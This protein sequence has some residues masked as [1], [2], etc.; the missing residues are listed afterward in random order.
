MPKI[1]L[2]RGAASCLLVLLFLFPNKTFA[3]RT[4][5][6]SYPIPPTN[7]AV[8][9][10]MK[11]AL[12][13]LLKEGRDFR[14]DEAAVEQDGGGFSVRAKATFFDVSSLELRASFSGPAAISQLEVA[15]P[16]S[17]PERSALRRLSGQ[18]LLDWVPEGLRNSVRLTRLRMGFENNAVSLVGIDLSSAPLKLFDQGALQVEALV[19]SFEV[20][21]PRAPAPVVRA[22]ISGQANAGFPI[23]VSATVANQ[24]DQWVLR[25]ETG[26]L[27]LGKVLGLTGVQRPAEWPDVL[28][29][30]G[31]ASG[32]IE[33]E[34]F[35]RRLSLRAESDFGQTEFA[36][37]ARPGAEPQ[38]LAGIALPAN[39]RFASIEPSLVVLDQ[40]GLSN[41]ALAL[42]SD[43]QT[44]S[45]KLFERLG[46]SPR[47]DRG[48][49][50]LAAYQISALS[51]DLESFMGQSNVLLRATIS[52]RPADLK[53]EAGL[54]TNIPFDD[55]GN[56]VLRGV[57]LT[58]APT[59]ASFT[60]SLG[61]A[62]DVRMEKD[63]LTFKSKI[64]VDLTNVELQVEGMMQGE[65]NNPF[66]IAPGVQLSNL[67][68]GFGVSFKTTPI[69]LPTLAFAGA[70][71]VGN[72]KKPAFAGDAAVAVDPSNPLNCMVDAGFNKI[73]LRD[74]VSACAP[75]AQIPAGLRNTILT[76]GIDS[77]RITIIPNPAGVV[78]FEKSYDPGFLVRGK[79][80]IAD[81][82]GELL[83][84]ISP[85]KGIDGKAGFSAIRQE[86]LFSLTGARGAPDPL[87][88]L[89]LRP[90][91]IQSS[92]LAISGKATLLGLSS[93]TDLLL[94]D[95]G[96][97]LFMEGKIFNLFQAN[98]N[99]S[100]GKVNNAADFYIKADMKNDL[101]QYISDN[102]S[103]EIDKATKD[104][105]SGIRS[106]QN[107]L[108]QKQR[109]V[110]TLNTEINR[111]RG[112]VQAERD[113]DCKKL[114]DAQSAV[115]AEQNKVNSLQSQ[116]NSLNATISKLKKE[117][118][119][120][121][122]KIPENSGKITYYGTQVAG[123]ETAKATARAALGAAK[124]TLRLM[125]DAC[126]ATPIDLDPRISGLLASRDIATGSMEAAKKILD[127]AGIIGV[128]TLKATKWI[129]TNGNPLGVV[130][131]RQAS[132]EG[133]LN[134]VNGG[135]V[136]MRV[137][138][139]FA[140]EPLNTSFAF[141]FNNPL[142]TVE[143]F[144]R[145]LLK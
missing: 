1:P 24:R 43:T 72:P 140:G 101:F 25:G 36:I 107:T 51:K 40:F 104:T 35:N 67:G 136:S 44:S 45:L 134:S 127:G 92:K 69:P 32:S 56:V 13:T 6:P 19:F 124:E 61:G 63:L 76:M 30:L 99:A 106:A 31:L 57:T 59:P 118:K 129:V 8:I 96:F 27:S 52:N 26:G 138:G 77:P 46:Q 137:Q 55:K 81:Y 3:A 5:D 21:N 22:R 85:T 131:I 83:L 128:G 82:Y 2:H 111:Q 50:L 109:E 97:N 65:W 126:K 114:R 53:L 80:S 115:T 49:T 41:T 62:M 119:S 47:I 91:D 112:I 120:K 71:K 64:G 12:A 28:W 139:T 144:A 132:F 39:F 70:L 87:V 89:A 20:E 16:G 145:E 116:I 48:L 14:I 130:N 113:R 29:D 93:E 88:Q 4:T 68:L 103:R 17:V 66:G 58:L 123:L 102:A 125:G 38:F 23:A 110:Q 79:A 37:S 60:V 117:M 10:Q 73:Y 54:E 18:N 33:L 100:A 86:P 95:N 105:Q 142:Q 9:Q 121:P 90:G 11:N 122:W 34:P 94:N 98:L 141:H 74:L 78:L 135:G 7:D 84:G 75:S 42:A 15:F 133:K 108:T 143:A